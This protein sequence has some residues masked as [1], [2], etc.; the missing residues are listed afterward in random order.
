MATKQVLKSHSAYILLY[1]RVYPDEQ[2][3]TQPSASPSIESI[4]TPSSS[5]SISLSHVKYIYG[6]VLCGDLKFQDASDTLE[7]TSPV[8]GPVPLSQDAPVLAA[9]GSVVP[10]HVEPVTV[11]DVV[12]SVPSKAELILRQNQNQNLLEAVESLTPNQ[13]ITEEVGD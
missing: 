6:I 13:I 8:P 11:S 10:G 5:D 3:T 2:A 9:A 4:T 7:S 1:S 12:A